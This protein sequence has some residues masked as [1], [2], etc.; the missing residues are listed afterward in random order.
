MIADIFNVMRKDL[1]E[2]VLQRAGARVTA[3][4]VRAGGG[5]LSLLILLAVFGIFL[6]YQSERAWV[7]SPIVILWAW[8]PLFLTSGLTADSFAGERERHTLETLLASRLSDTAILLGKVAAAIAYG[9]GVT[10]ASLLLGLVTV[11]VAFGRGELIMYPPG[12]A[13]A[14]LALSFLGAGLSAT[15]GVLVSLR[16]AT[17]RQAAQTMSIAI[18]LLLFVPIFGLQALPPE[19]QDRLLR[20]VTSSSMDQIL[21]AALAVLLVVDAA[22]LAAGLARFKRAKLILD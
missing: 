15:A 20:W 2:F 13:L 11:N 4:G 1:K 21:L 7:E 16:A 19:T 5:W 17:V 10:V 18:M 12:M 22:L 6:P 9:W 8:V 3:A 14:G